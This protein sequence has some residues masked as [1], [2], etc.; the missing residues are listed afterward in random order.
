MEL[1]LIFA[2]DPHGGIG[3]ANRLPWHVSADLRHFRRLT[4][5]NMVIMG[6]NTWESMGSKPLPGRYNVVLS[7]RPRKTDDCLAVALEA[8]MA[9][10]AADAGQRDLL[11]TVIWVEDPITLLQLLSFGPFRNLLPCRRAFVIGGAEIYTAF[12]ELG[13]ISTVYMTEIRGGTYDTDVKLTFIP[14]LHSS[15]WLRRTLDMLTEEERVGN[16]ELA[17]AGHALFIFDHHRQEEQVRNL[18]LRLL[19]KTGKPSALRIDRTGVGIYSVFAPQ[20]EF[21]LRGG[22][23]PLLTLRRQ[24]LRGIFEE[25]MWMLRGQTDSRIL[26][27]KGLSIWKPNTTRAFLDEQ[28]LSLREGD[29]GGTYGFQYRH[30]GAEYRGCDQDYGGQGVDQLDAI[31]Q[32]LRHNPASRRIL[33]NL[34]NPAEKNVALPPCVFGYQFFVE[35]GQLH[36]KMFQRSSDFV[37]AGGWNI[38]A[39]ALFTHLLARVCGLQ[40]ARLVWSA[41]DVHLYANQVEQCRAIVQQRAFPFPRVAFTKA[42]PTA[43]ITDFEFHHLRLLNYVSSAPVKVPMNQ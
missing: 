33:I 40:A 13:C 21:D 18:M 30:F 11:S 24:N 7:R 19:E 23:L 26:E 28:G 1:S 27:E 17:A 12:M 39:G 34:W 42:A 9:S 38:A 14:Q 20:L 31:V 35:E 22:V 6:R 32:Q 3:L 36:T 43:C 37:L 10:V 16:D 2:C 41:G 5:G 8:D 29:I 25:L 4:S 15:E